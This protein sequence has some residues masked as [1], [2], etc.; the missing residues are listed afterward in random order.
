MLRLAALSGA[1]GKREIHECRLWENMRM[2]SYRSVM[3]MKNI[4]KNELRKIL[5][6]FQLDVNK[7][8]KPL[9]KYKINKEYKNIEIIG[10]SC[11]GKTTLLEKMGGEFYSESELYSIPVWSGDYVVGGEGW[12]SLEKL[13]EIECN[14]IF[15]ECE[16]G[17]E[18]YFSLRQALELV[19]RKTILDNYDFKK[20]FVLSDGFFQRYCGAICYLEKMSESSIKEIFHGWKI[21]NMKTFDIDFIV[22]NVMRRRSVST[23]YSYR[24]L[25]GNDLVAEIKRRSLECEKFMDIAKKYGVEAIEVDPLKDDSYAEVVEFIK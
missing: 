25:V 17:G 13:L 19:V 14:N 11:S 12:L 22:N 21:I 10:P 24:G 18:I 6:I 9:P 3:K 2:N 8:C 16:R 5:D 7:I 20:K 1:D 4:V 23:G 15:R